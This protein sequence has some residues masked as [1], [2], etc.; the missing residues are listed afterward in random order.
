MTSYTCIALVLVMV[1]VLYCNVLH[2]AAFFY[3]ELYTILPHHTCFAFFSCYLL[4]PI[5]C[6]PFLE[7][8]CGHVIRNIINHWSYPLLSLTHSSPP[9]RRWPHG[10]TR[11]GHRTPSTAR[12]KEQRGVPHSHGGAMSIWSCA[13]LLFVSSCVRVRAC[14]FVSFSYCPSLL[15]CQSVCLSIYLSVCLLQSSMSFLV[16]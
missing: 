3:V 6:I 15:V 10:K 12:L 16:D 11:Q 7:I 14:L 1:T 4:H 5:N 8:I 13:V 2:C 9:I